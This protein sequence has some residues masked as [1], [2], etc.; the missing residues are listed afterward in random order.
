MKRK[1]VNYINN[2]DLLA[3][4]EAWLNNRK[5]L[6]AKGEPM[7]QIPRYIGEAIMLIANRLARKGNFSGYSFREEMVSDGIEN[8]IMYLHNFNP[9]KSK[10]PFGYISLILHNAY[11]RRIEKESKHSYIKH[12]LMFNNSMYNGTGEFD[13]SDQEV[14]SSVMESSQN[15]KS[16]DVI[17]KFEDRLKDKKEK[18]ARKDAEKNL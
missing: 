15:D 17:S 3:A 11:I 4:M 6:L 16:G 9:A 12:K 10:N 7:P 8:C 13:Q 1:S 2:A 5:E 18:K 14:I